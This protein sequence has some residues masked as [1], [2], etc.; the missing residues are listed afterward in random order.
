[1]SESSSDFA[2][3]LQKFDFDSFPNA[4]SR[5]EALAA[6]RALVT[7][8][9]TPMDTFSHMSHEIP[10]L[11]AALKVGMLLNVFETLSQDNGSAKSASQ[12]AGNADP[13]LVVRCLR[14]LASMNIIGEAGPDLFVPTRHSSALLNPAVSATIDYFRDITSKTFTSLPAFLEHTHFKNPV[15]AAAGN[16]QY[17]LGRD[18]SYFQWM[19]ENPDKS[20][21][22]TNIMI[23]YNAQWDS[24]CEV[25]P[26]HEL[27]DNAND[28]DVLI[29]DIGKPHPSDTP[30]EK[31]ECRVWTC[32]STNG[33]I[34]AVEVVM[35]S[36]GFSKNIH[37]LLV[38]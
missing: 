18:V 3:H 24:W 21:N 15:Y 33:H 5:R 36:H 13:A 29:V 23:G 19:A 26:G 10:A 22:F 2:Q 38:G 1:M 4:G 17:L 16:W 37:N 32:L 9:E 25:Y 20:K 31:Y 28:G 11:Y 8:L 30:P 7:R 14:H 6:A 35:I 12:L 27:L 34:Q